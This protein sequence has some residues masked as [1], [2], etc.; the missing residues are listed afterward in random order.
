MARLWTVGLALAV[1]MVACLATDA[2]A[3]TG[4]GTSTIVLN[5]SAVSLQQGASIQVAYTVKLASGNTWGTD[6]VIDNAAQLGSD[7]LTLSASATSGDPTFSG[8]LTLSASSSAAAG[9]Y[10]ATLSATGDDPTAN[11][12]T[13]QIT[14]LAPGATSASTTVASTTSTGNSTA[15]TSRTTS[16]APTS[17]ASGSSGYN[18]TSVPSTSGYGGGVWP[19]A[20]A[21]IIILI[22]GIATAMKKKAPSSRLI[23]T[24]VVL[25]LIGVVVWLYG[26]YN[27]GIMA[28]IWGGVAAILVGTAV[29]LLGDHKGKLI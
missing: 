3:A 27:G 11:A 25:I 7:G 21:I 13:L 26:D 1:A 24:G 29:W 20:V 18:Y 17:T 10:N 12:T 9:Q 19:Y 23:V 5:N 22:A 8:V 28:Y 15:T 2:S 14:V 6:L 4:Y 16:Q